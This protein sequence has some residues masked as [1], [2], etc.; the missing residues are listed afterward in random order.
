MC[1]LR[2]ESRLSMFLQT[3]T[4]CQ[5]HVKTW[6]LFSLSIS[7]YCKVNGAGRTTS[8][9]NCTHV[10]LR[11]VFVHA[12]NLHNTNSIEP[13]I[14]TWQHSSN[15][16]AHLKKKNAIALIQWGKVYRNDVL[17]DP[18]KLACNIVQSCCRV[19][20]GAARLVWP[21]LAHTR[22]CLTS[23]CPVTRQKAASS[24]AAAKS[25]APAAMPAAPNAALSNGGYGLGD[26][27]GYDP[28][29]ESTP[30]T[31]DIYGGRWAQIPIMASV[32]LTDVDGFKL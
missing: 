9:L 12:D 18:F 13:G 22:P 15:T 32:Y 23:D 24:R 17:L 25:P 14:A 31:E 2:L 21:A 28:A 7:P 26:D 29:D 5:A 3:S 19:A 8:A 11:L 30:L 10:R 27:D 1:I 20:V 16:Q 4:A 6:Q